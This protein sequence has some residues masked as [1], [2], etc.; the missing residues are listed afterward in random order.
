M[1]LHHQMTPVN[2]GSQPEASFSAAGDTKVE[3]KGAKCQEDEREGY[4]M[5]GVLV[6][7]AAAACCWGHSHP[8]FDGTT[9]A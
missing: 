5:H 9:R 4:A 2:D 1:G 6:G 8:G 7:G 3:G